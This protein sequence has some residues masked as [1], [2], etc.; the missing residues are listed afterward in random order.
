MIRHLS[1][2][3]SFPVFFCSLT[4]FSVEPPKNPVGIDF[5]YAGFRAG[6]EPI[7]LVRA[8]LS[9][10]PTGGDDTALLQ[11]A[12]D[13]VSAMPVGT[14][15]FRGAVLL[16]PGRFRVQGEL[17]MSASGIVL[18]GSGTGAGGTTIV[19]D[20]NDRRT[21][22]QVGNETKPILSQAVPVV[23][24]L[25]EAGARSFHVGDVSG[26]HAGTR[27]VIRRPSTAAWIKA[28]GMSG[29][30]GTFA[31]Q[32]I[33]WKPGSHDLVWNRTITR[34][35]AASKQVEFDAPITMRLE[36]AWGGATVAA[37]TSGGPATDIGIENLTFDSAYDTA[38]V[39]DEEHSWI[40]IA[41]DHVEDA[42]VR[43]VIGRHFVASLVRADQQARRVTIEDC[44]SEQPIS[45]VGGYR[46]QNFLVY[47][48]Q[49]LVYR[50]HSEAGMNDFATGL[51]AAGPNVFLDC[52]ARGSLEASGS[53]EGL[54]AGVLYEGVHVPDSRIQLLLDQ[55]RAQAAGWTA[56]NSLIWNSTAQSL[57]AMGPYDG[58][59]YV[60]ESPQSLYVSELTARALRLPQAASFP[61]GE[62]AP[63]FHTIEKQQHETVPQ[64]PFTIVNG[65]LVVDG[66]V[67]YG[68]SQNETWWHGNTSPE[69]AGALTGS[70]ITRFMPGQT[71]PGLTEDLHELVTRVLSHGNIM[72]QSIPGLW[73]EHRRDE[74]T[75][76]RQPNGDVWAPFFE[77]PWAR[78]GKGIA[79][80]GLSKYDLSRYNPW[81]FKRNRDFIRIAGEHGLIVIH[82]LYN[83]HDVFEI[84]PHWID[85]PWRPA[86]NI[87]D[88]G[89]PEP[90]PFA[91]GYTVAM[92][93]VQ[94]TVT[95]LNVGNQF[96]SVDYAPLRKLHHDYIFHVLDELGDMPNVIFTVA[97]QYAGPLAFEQ[98]FLDT[99]REWEKQHN[100]HIRIALITSKGITDAILA[101]PVR[102]KQIAVVDMRYWYYLADGTLFAPDAG[103]NR[104]FRDLITSR[105]QGPYT[106]TGPATTQEQVY[107]EVREYRDRYPDL[108]LLPMENGAGP[109]PLLM[110]GASSPSSLRSMEDGRSKSLSNDEVID[111]FIRENLSTDLM[112]MH[113]VDDLVSDPTENWVLAG[114]TTDAVL[115]YSKAGETLS[116]AKNLPLNNYAGTW[117]DP[118]TARSRD[119]GQ[120]MGQAGVRIMKPDGKAWLLQLRASAR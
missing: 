41:L 42:W 49:V 103:Q 19:A 54:A 120:L 62:T 65:Y 102:S 100:R 58:Y 111:K 101:D 24:T 29:L 11:S 112:K 84:G 76:F 33:D 9:V 44:R 47:G 92:D 117:F 45:E 81:Y 75:V 34:V 68:T 89:L 97:Y 55:T 10:R 70:S 50:S 105:F 40:A 14:D 87:N 3:V 74:H 106:N 79:W 63:E 16:S 52:D 72:Y 25:V 56:V 18:R 23:D 94:P 1:R 64:H 59:N 39:K 71:V 109:L 28:H 38:N 6:T 83:S 61:M 91:G 37:V 46:R 98:F 20:G 7:P 73:Y 43:N 114:E 4:C 96:Y 78:S 116:F 12:I 27:I 67:A 36:T 119:A 88:T 17:R 113:P 13:A 26:F 104:A 90:P 30:L 8:R 85:Y 48:Q 32:R 80:D 110:G 57:D 35:D 86:N 107:R 51:L 118:A 53:F 93:T 95:K 82:N 60:V 115:I 77:M 22:I 66:K 99:V 15:G 2:F 5:S 21:L 69:V 108:V 31:D